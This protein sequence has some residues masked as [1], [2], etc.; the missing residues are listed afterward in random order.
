[1][2]ATFSRARARAASPRVS[3]TTARALVVLAAAAICVLARPTFVL[4]DG[5]GRDRGAVANLAVEPANDFAYTTTAESPSGPKYANARLEHVRPDER[6]PEPLVS[7]S[8]MDLDF[9]GPTLCS[10]ASSHVT[11]MNKDPTKALKVTSVTTDHLAFQP[12]NFTPVE[13]P[14]MGRARVKLA[15]IPRALGA[16]HASFMVHTSVGA[17]IVR[18]KANAVESP[19]KVHPLVGAQIQTG[20]PHVYRLHVHN[21]HAT[22]LTVTSVD[23]PDDFMSLAPAGRDERDHSSAFDAETEYELQPDGA[24]YLKKERTYDRSIWEIEPGETRAIVLV[25][26]DAMHDG[27]HEGHVRVSM[28]HGEAADGSMRDDGGG[29]GGGD[30]GGGGVGGFEGFEDENATATRRTRA[31]SGSGSIDARRVARAE[32][33]I[34]VHAHA[35]PTGVFASPDRI[36]FGVATR[37]V[38]RLRTSLSL[39]NGADRPTRILDVHTRPADPSFRWRYD[40]D[41]LIAPDASALNAIEF[42]YSGKLAGE[43]TGNVFVKMEG[44]RRPIVVPYR[45]RVFHGKLQIDDAEVSF[46][47]PD[48]DEGGDG[49]FDAISNVV[50]VKNKFPTPIKF[51]SAKVTRIEGVD[52]D[53]IADDKIASFDVSDVDLGEIVL[54]EGTLSPFTLEWT[55]TRAGASFTAILA[56]E[57]DVTTLEV[58]VRVYDGKLTCVEDDA[59]IAIA[60]S[61]ESESES[62]AA[63]AAA[64][65]VGCADDRTVSSIDFGVVGAPATRTKRFAVGNPNPF[66]IAMTRAV[67]TVRAVRASRVV[68]LAPDGEESGAREWILDARRRTC[69]GDG[70]S[71]TCEQATDAVIPPGGVAVVDVVAD[72]TE[73]EIAPDGAVVF[74]F[75]N[76]RELRT[77]VSLR[78]V[79]GEIVVKVAPLPPSHPGRP[80]SSPLIVTNTFAETVTL[81]DVESDDPAIRFVPAKAFAAGGARPKLAP[82]VETVVGE[83]HFDPSTLPE[84]A[85]YLGGLVG[86][87]G[88]TAAERSLGELTKSHAEELRRA[89]VAWLA[90][91]AGRDDDGAATTTLRLRADAVDVTPVPV[92]TTLVRPAIIK[93]EFVDVDRGEDGGATETV[94]DEISFGSA[95]VGATGRRQARV[96]VV[97]PSTTGTMCASSPPLTRVSTRATRSSSGGGDASAKPG[98]G[99]GH[100]HGGALAAAKAHLA[101]DFPGASVVGFTVRDGDVASMLGKRRRWTFKSGTAAAS[102]GDAPD[103]VCLGP[104]ERALLG[105][106][107]FQPTRAGAHAAHMCARNDLSVLSCVVLRGEGAEPPKLKTRMVTYKTHTFGSAHGAVTDV[108]FNTE[109]AEGTQAVTVAV[110][111]AGNRPVS[112][113]PPKI[114]TTGKCAWGGISVDPCEETYLR[115]GQA[116]P[117]TVTYTPSSDD[118]RKPPA[119]M[120]LMFDVAA[121]G[122]DRDDVVDGDAETLWTRIVTTATA[123]TGAY[124]EG[125]YVAAR[126]CEGLMCTFQVTTSEFVVAVLAV[127]VAY[128]VLFVQHGVHAEEPTGAKG[129]SAGAAKKGD[130][131][132]ETKKGKEAKEEEAAAAAA[133]EEE[134]LNKEKAAAKKLMD[135]LVAEAAA[136]KLMDELVAEEEEKRRKKEEEKRRKK[137]EEE[138]E[139]EE[140]AAAAAEVAPAPPPADETRREETREIPK[141]TT[142]P[143]PPVAVAEHRP[144]VPAQQAKKSPV[145]TPRTATAAAGAGIGFAAGTKQPPAPKSAETKFPKPKWMP[146]PRDVVAPAVARPAP[147]PSSTPALATIAATHPP[148]AP[149]R[150]PASFLPPR[151]PDWITP[152]NAEAPP[153]VAPP[154]LVAPPAASRLAG[155]YATAPPPA[156]TTTTTTTTTSASWN[157]HSLLTP[158]DLAAM[159]GQG[160]GGGGG[161]APPGYGGGRP[162]NVDD[163]FGPTAG[164]AGGGGGGGARGY[165][166]W[167]GDHFSRMRAASPV[168]AA[169]A[170]GNAGSGFA[171]PT[172][173]ANAGLPSFFGS[174]ANAVDDDA[175]ECDGDGATWEEQNKVLEDLNLH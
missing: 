136:K 104:T 36:D 108:A 63:G 134:D 84:D 34:P 133:K 73:D 8:P 139:E 112:V 14:P 24:T 7:I 125:E 135:E 169:G 96:Y 44:Q 170:G 45:A 110:F 174:A 117:I 22:P 131:A 72:V 95:V 142:K 148:P 145:P 116:S 85:A 75:D 160:G 154:P 27:A 119:A 175:L 50:T 89:N 158:S 65:V 59:A 29:G 5:V 141:E 16:S 153:P 105:V 168:G 114:G 58:P 41:A 2:A 30:D 79:T 1:M 126:A 156:Q 111:N 115:A 52:D 150:P 124:E 23:T 74:A 164:A 13:L 37:R 21:P 113:S 60:A 70:S 42:T 43:R 161:R 9:G 165:D 62:A 144:V 10:V 18:A 166:I 68:V 155:I 61:I 33:H 123:S 99:A 132:M 157:G 48:E 39:F 57:T 67:S 78:A 40:K 101:G 100:D 140:A 35:S 20:V 64:D 66:A 87:A 12:A 28:E 167:G 32:L 151:R 94:G 97:N 159:I 47:S 118:S 162:P 143:A 17:F 51:L 76:G 121:R 102:D 149:P 25:R 4:A 91:A 56:F 127:V 69:D 171:S 6:V 122:E 137:K 46:I 82:N 26:V 152:P 129:T 172:A 3:M 98:V 11:V 146:P 19:Y 55:P 107:A 147:P 93:W 81:A 90:A 86:A 38:D 49:P 128:L 15:F 138:E 106:V 77:R 163:M 109:A 103:R 92:T 71:S 80:A 53:K 173:N 88:E 130:G 83:V 31:G 120:M 54:S